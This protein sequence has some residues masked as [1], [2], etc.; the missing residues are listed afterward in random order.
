MLD[1]ICSPR[2]R[3]S[4]PGNGSTSVV[5]TSASS[6]SSLARSARAGASTGMR[7]FV[8][9]RDCDLLIASGDEGSVAEDDDADVEEEVAP[10][11]AAEVFLS[12]TW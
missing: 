3:A 4:I 1:A 5:Q 2:D 12:M 6:A 8:V 7:L 10:Y 9:R 11:F